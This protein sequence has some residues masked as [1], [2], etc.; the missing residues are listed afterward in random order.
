MLAAGK[1]NCFRIHIHT[2]KR[3]RDGW[4]SAPRRLLTQGYDVRGE[5]V[6][7]QDPSVP[8]AVQLRYE[9]VPVDDQ[10]GT[11]PANDTEEIR[12]SEENTH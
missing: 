6:S 10:T 4:D 5:A 7:Q 11:K 12:F 9:P 8:L 2:N 3:P 1:L